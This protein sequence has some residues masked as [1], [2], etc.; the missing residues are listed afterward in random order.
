MS[1]LFLPPVFSACSNN[2]IWPEFGPPSEKENRHSF[3]SVRPSAHGR[4]SADF[5]FPDARRRYIGDFHSAWR[6]ISR[7]D[8][9]QIETQFPIKHNSTSSSKKRT[10]LLKRVRIFAQ[11][12]FLLSIPPSFGHP[13]G[14]VGDSSIRHRRKGRRRDRKTRKEGFSLDVPVFFVRALKIE[15]K[16]KKCVTSSLY[17]VT[18]RKKGRGEKTKKE[19]CGCT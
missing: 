10:F 18:C 1:R 3:L 7:K 2:R 15:G 4:A 12:L 6:R 5:P 8:I 11:G 17:P 9:H 14:N 13:G 16:E 19:R